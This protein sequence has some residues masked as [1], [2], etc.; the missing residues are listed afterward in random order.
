MNSMN[1]LLKEIMFDMGD[2]EVI[3]KYVS[4]MIDGDVNQ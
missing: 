3:V 4:I 1:I 2:K